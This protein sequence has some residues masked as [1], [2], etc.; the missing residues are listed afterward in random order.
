MPMRASLRR[1][2]ALPKRNGLL[3]LFRL[4]A[5]P[6]RSRGSHAPRRVADRPDRERLNLKDLLPRCRRPAEDDHPPA[7]SVG[8]GRQ[9]DDGPDR[10][11]VLLARLAPGRFPFRSQSDKLY[12]SVTLRDSL[13][14][15][16]SVTV[17]GL[18]FGESGKEVTAYSP[19]I[20]RE[21]WCLRPIPV[22][23]R[24]VCLWSFQH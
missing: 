4:P 9:D 5:L 11:P 22:H 19:G 6:T 2:Q 23:L 1:A 10:P 12:Q 20:M 17:G 18:S 21:P 3:G 14:W 15:Y 13:G 24:H 16:S 7:L 8:T